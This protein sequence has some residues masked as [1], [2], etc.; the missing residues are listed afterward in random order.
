MIEKEYERMYIERKRPLEKQYYFYRIYLKPKTPVIPFTGWLKFKGRKIEELPRARNVSSETVREIVP[1][2]FK[3]KYKTLDEIFSTNNLGIVDF[4]GKGC[5]IM[6]ENKKRE[7]KFSHPIHNADPP[8]EEGHAEKL[9]TEQPE[10]IDIE[11][12]DELLENSE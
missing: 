10:E 12:L 9:P 8:F 5:M 4:D 3:E 2:Y 1:K 11:G 6:Y 7:L